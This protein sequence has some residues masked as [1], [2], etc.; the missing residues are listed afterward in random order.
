MCQYFSPTIFY[1]QNATLQSL[2]WDILERTRQQIFLQKFHKCLAVLGYFANCLF[3]A[4]W[5]TFVEKIGLLISISS[6]TGQVKYLKYGA[7][8]DEW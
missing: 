2:D 5:A 1:Y 8:P 4:L 3:W 7:F 6:H